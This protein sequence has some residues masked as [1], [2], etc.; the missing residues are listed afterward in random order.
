MSDRKRS[1]T[2]SAA[3]A[4]RLLQA[5]GWLAEQPPDLQR[6]IF[7]RGHFRHLPPGAPVFLRGDQPDGIYAVVRGQIKLAH[8]LPEGRE[9]VLWAAEPGFWF[10]VRDLVVP[11][12]VRYAA[13]V[14]AH[15]TT[16]FHLPKSALHEVIAVDPGYAINFAGIM[17][18]NL[19]LALRYISEVL[20][21][22][23]EIRVAR[24]LALLC[25]TAGADEAGRHELQLSQQD[26]AA[27]VGASRVTV[28][29][30]LRNLA[31]RRLITLR[32]RRIAVLNL[33]ELAGSL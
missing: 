31:A 2:V 23:M 8:I 32:Y 22:P 27:M 10:G 21:Q 33:P 17:A 11:Q 15:P 25:E 16:V 9:V 1:V 5:R 7:L 6:A 14:A 13:A 3:E 19:L 28:G 30:A 4:R 20:S 29:K 26:L 24:L 18:H 12:A